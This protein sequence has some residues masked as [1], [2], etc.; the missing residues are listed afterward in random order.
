VIRIECVRREVGSSS[1]ECVSESLHRGGRTFALKR[2][3][4]LWKT[5]SSFDAFFSLLCELLSTS[6]RARPTQSRRIFTSR[7]AV[8]ICTVVCRDG[9]EP[10]TQPRIRACAQPRLECTAPGAGPSRTA[11]DA[12]VRSGTFPMCPC[13]AQR[14]GSYRARRT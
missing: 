11:S 12:V 8:G 10:A 3:A 1:Q 13:A 14:G 4:A 9:T 5:A 2:T 6:A 7:A